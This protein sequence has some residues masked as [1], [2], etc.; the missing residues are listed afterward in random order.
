VPRRGSNEGAPAAGAVEPPPG[1]LASAEE[2]GTLLGRGAT[3]GGGSETTAAPREPKATVCTG[4]R[5][6][7]GSEALVTVVDPGGLLP[8]GAGAELR[9]PSSFVF[10][11][12]PGGSLYP[13]AGAGRLERAELAALVA[14]GMVA[15]AAAALAAAVADAG[16]ELAARTVAVPLVS[17]A[18][19][20]ALRT[21]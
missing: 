12:R 2:G 9:V 18:S 13:T 15:L 3:G 20:G 17:A 7:G 11:A 5:F 19:S 10:W 6:F 8:V 21:T 14:E 1:D 4:V 16:G